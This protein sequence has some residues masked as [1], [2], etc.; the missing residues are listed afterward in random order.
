MVCQPEEEGA[1]EA[2]ESTQHALLLHRCTAHPA[3]GWG[4]GLEGP[5]AAGG[6]AGLTIR[7]PSPPLV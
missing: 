5:C 6:Q 7:P 1:E 4:A 2:A 3:Q